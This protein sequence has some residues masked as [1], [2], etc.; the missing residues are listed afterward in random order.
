MG[1]IPVNSPMLKAEALKGSI[2]LIK[3]SFM[4]SHGWLDAFVPQHKIKMANLNGQSAEPSVEATEQW[5]SQLPNFLKGTPL[6]TFIIETGQDW[7][8]LLG[9]SIKKF[10]MAR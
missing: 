3:D 4:A 2:K 8:F 1:K 10:C 9:C 6:M 5:K 7:H